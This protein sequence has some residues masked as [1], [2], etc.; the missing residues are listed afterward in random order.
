MIFF[1]NRSHFRSTFV[2]DLKPERQSRLFKEFGFMCDCEACVKDY[3]TPPALNFKDAKLLKFAKKAD[4]E[5]L[6]LPF[7]K[8]V[9]RYRDCCEAID[10]N[11][12]NFPS[13]ELC[14]LQK[15]ISAF[16]L[17]QAKPKVLFS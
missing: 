6:K 9:K 1:A 8:A 2:K 13:F 10:K 11:N 15:C 14:L 7:N 5:M 12:H 17:N 4:E 3:A 16:L